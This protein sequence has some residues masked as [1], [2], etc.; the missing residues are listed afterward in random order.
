VTAEARDACVRLAALADT[1]LLGIELARGRGG[2]SFVDASPWPDLTVGGEAL[3][4]ALG[5]AL[6]EP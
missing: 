3:L 1:P 4:D 6:R 5:A 2:W